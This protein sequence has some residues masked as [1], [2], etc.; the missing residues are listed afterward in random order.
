MFLIERLCHR[1]LYLRRGRI[2]ADGDPV[3]VTKQFEKDI[4]SEFAE[5]DPLAPPLEDGVSVVAAKRPQAA[6]NDPMPKPAARIP[7]AKLQKEP[8]LIRV[9]EVFT[10]PLLNEDGTEAAIDF[11]RSPPVLHQNLVQLT[12][13]WC[14]NE[15]GQKCNVFRC[16]E[17]I[18]LIFQV[19]SRVKKEHINV[20]AMIFSADGFHI[21]TTTNRYSL[22]VDG[23]PEPTIINLA[24]GLQII[25]LR[26][27]K[28]HLAAGRYLVG[29]GITPTIHHFSSL[30][31]LCEAERCIAFAVHRDDLSQTV[32]YE[33][34][35]NWRSE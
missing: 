8:A 28:C 24:F 7:L 19:T 32:I 26:L 10:G 12:G 3:Q 20:G 25:R 9:D 34:E 23:R 35:S 1:V 5:R 17:T 33:P 16:G 31:K 6:L 4:M 14:E 27:P 21:V 18:E 13:C 2:E 22:D 29:F 30:D 15:E 11:S